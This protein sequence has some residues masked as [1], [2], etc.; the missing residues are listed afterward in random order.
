MVEY[1]SVQL[2][3]YTYWKRKDQ[4]A[5]ERDIYDQWTMFVVEEGRFRY[6]IAENFGEAGFGELVICPPQTWF[7]R[8]VIEPLSFYFMHFDRKEAVHA[9]C[10]DEFFHCP[11]HAVEDT[12]RLVSTFRLLNSLQGG[13]KAGYEEG[14][15]HLLDDLLFQL[16]CEREAR[17]RNRLDVRVEDAAMQGAMNWMLEHAYAPFSM[18]QLA[19]N[20]HITPV[21]LTRRFRSAFGLTPLEYV[22]DLRL[23]RAG[24]LLEE[25]S[26]NLEQIAQQCG[27]E[28]GFYLSRIFHKKK[29]ISPSLYRKMKRV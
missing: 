4:F 5:L 16:G 13:S 15:Q 22:T 2:Y 23:N 12:Q 24:Q 11:K 3:S 29:G 25:S 17:K 20:L 27:Y 26:L 1:S 14:A 6:R 19:N 7:C 8:E 28:N 9:A 21:Q 18:R 10:D